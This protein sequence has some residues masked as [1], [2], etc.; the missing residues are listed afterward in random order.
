MNTLVRNEEVD[1]GLTGGEPDGADLEVLYAGV[2][3][4]VAVLPEAAS[5]SRA[6]GEGHARRSCG[7]RRSC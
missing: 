1:I 7:R 5:R 4:L 3:R 6:G 2:D